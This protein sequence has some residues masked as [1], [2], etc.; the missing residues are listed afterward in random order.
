MKE[1]IISIII[2]KSIHEVFEFSTNPQ[3]THLWVDSIKEEMTNEYPPK[4]GTI[5][6]N[7]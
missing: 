3:N 2:N 6:K 5:Y 4:L 7:R 1:N